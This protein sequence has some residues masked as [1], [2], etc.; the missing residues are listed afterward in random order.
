MKFRRMA[1]GR[2][3]VVAAAFLAVL[4]GLLSTS[5]FVVT[6]LAAPV[7]PTPASS[8]RAADASAQDGFFDDSDAPDAPVIVSG[9]ANPTNRTTAEFTFIDEDWPRVRFSCQLD[10]GPVTPCTG[11]TDHDGDWWRYPWWDSHPDYSAGRDYWAA[12]DY[13]ADRDYWDGRLE[14]EQRYEG[15]APGRHCF[16]VYATG[17]SGKVSPTTSY[18]WTIRGH[19]VNF[20][21]GGDLTSPLYPGTSQPLDLTFTNPNSSAITI[22]SNGISSS[23]IAISTSK[24][25]CSASNFAVLQGLTASVTIPAHATAESLHDLGVPQA[26]WPIITMLETNTNQ[27]ACQGATLTFIYSGIEATG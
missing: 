1:A 16:Y 17:K 9:P 5:Y 22:A 14:G 13:W 19:T 12:H 7:P 2:R 18:C 25:G 24:A 23:N 15:L 8:I 3:R 20:T 11:D 21:V 10:S 27:D 4:A 26:N 6:A